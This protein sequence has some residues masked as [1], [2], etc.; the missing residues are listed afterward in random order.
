MV[1]IQSEIKR[2]FLRQ[3]VAGAK[4]NAAT[5][6]ESLLNFQASIYTPN[7]AKGKILVSTSGS[8]QQGSFEIGVA[9]KQFTQENVFAMSEEFFIIYAAALAYNT[10]LTDSGQSADSDAIFNAMLSDDVLNSV[11][12]QLGDWSQLNAYASN[13]AAITT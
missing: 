10:D 4:R 3:I 7:F 12:E 11:T 6:N 1:R 5:I 8:G 2:G 13:A 9:G